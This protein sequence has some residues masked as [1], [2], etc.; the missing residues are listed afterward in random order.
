M[1]SQATTRYTLDDLWDF[2]DDRK[3][4]ELID[5]V[6]YVTPQARVRHQRV[7]F[8]ITHRIGDWVDEHG[9]DVFGPANVDLAFDTHFEPDVV[10]LTPEHAPAE[11]LAVTFPPDLLVEVSSPSTRS[12]DLGV[13]RRAY[14][15][16]GVTE[17]WF[18]D[19]VAE[20]ILVHR[21]RDG[22]Y[23]EPARYGRG[24]TFTSALLPG[25]VLDV[26]DL[27]GAPER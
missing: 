25:L 9:G 16:H 13:K 3:R 10:F 2:P 19:L 7:I 1:E 4:R 15:R 12:Y 20:E 26:D 21:L 24:G 22:R 5:G 17:Y 23:G 14:E 6:L 27:L 18:A 8:K 11:G